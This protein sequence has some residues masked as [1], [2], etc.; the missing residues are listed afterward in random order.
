MAYEKT[1]WQTGDI[2]TAQKLNN[3]E[4]GI[5]DSNV[6]FL[7]EDSNHVLDKTWQEINDA[8]ALGKIIMLVDEEHLSGFRFLFSEEASGYYWLLSL[9]MQYKADSPDDYPV[10]YNT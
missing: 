9:S 2:V 8:L 5:F 4:N 10:Y 3:I 6:I 1:T 7:S